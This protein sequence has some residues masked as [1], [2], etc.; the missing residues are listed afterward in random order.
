M[1]KKYKFWFITGSQDLYGTETIKEVFSHSK[2]MVDFLNT[3]SDFDIV[4]K[5]VVTTPEEIVNT[6]SQA[7]ADPN[8]GGIITWMHTFSPSKM[9]INGLKLN[10]KPIL[11]LH[12]QYNREIP[13]DKIDMD[14]MNTNQAA[15]GDREHGY[16]YTRMGLNRKVIVGYYQD[17]NVYSKINKWFNVANAA[18]NSRSLKVARF[19]DN[20]RE[21]AVTDGDKVG[22][23][24][25]LGWSVN[26]YAVGDLV[27]KINA[28]PQS[29]VDAL[30]EEYKEIYTISEDT[31]G[32]K[33]K[34][35]SI[36]YQGKLE[37]GIKAF[38]EEGNFGA[39]TNTFEDLYGMEQLP[40]LASQRLMEQGYGFGPEGDWKVSAMLRLINIMTENK[41]TSLMEDY[42]YHLAKGNQMILGAHMLEVCPNLAPS[43]KDVS[44][45]VHKLGIGGKKAPARMVFEGKEGSGVCV[46]LVDM[47]GRLRLIV[48]D[49]EA[50]AIPEKMPN[51]PVAGVMW[52]PMPNMETAAAAWIYA[53]GA[54]HTVFSYDVDAQDMIDF[55]EIMDIE[56][57]HINK[58]TDINSL[59]KELM[60]NDILWKLK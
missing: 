27:K 41:G 37:L 58:N 59:K 38:L 53:G 16:I 45:E 55:A 20:M 4:H 49:V 12:T 22:T 46:S 56:Y 2:E 8:C 60:M 48:L 30:F 11:H 51:L 36:K 34:V 23:Q 19:G 43:K 1:I 10:N 35:E 44:I 28:V 5:G 54:H 29:D 52:K 24:I 15:H 13:W 42:T 6:F 25:Q 57:V 50:I 21:V 14:F 31:L 39:Y 47:G 40:G 17:E 7:N 32:D 26:Y 3:K 18:T 9:W 33:E